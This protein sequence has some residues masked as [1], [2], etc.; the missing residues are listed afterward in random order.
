MQTLCTFIGLMEWWKNQEAV[1]VI[2]DFATLQGL[3]K[4]SSSDPDDSSVVNVSVSLTPF[5]FSRDL[6]NQARSIQKHI[7]LLVDAISRDHHFLTE[8]LKRYV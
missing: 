4:K 2:K 8:I 7:N 6:F 1:E 5:K 3:I